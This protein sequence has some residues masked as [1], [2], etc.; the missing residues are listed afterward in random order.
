MLPEYL[1]A[2][3]WAVVIVVAVANIIAFPVAGALILKPVDKQGVGVALGFFL[4]P[5][6]LVIAWAKRENELL[7]R[8]EYKER[9]RVALDDVRTTPTPGARPAWAPDEAPRRFR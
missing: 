1:A 4:G 9:H 7:E 6:G 2:A 3:V 5:I 8:R